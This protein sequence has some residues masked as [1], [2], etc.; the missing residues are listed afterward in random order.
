MLAAA[1]AEF[2]KFRISLGKAVPAGLDLH[3]MIRPALN[4]PA[5]ML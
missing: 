1:A 5:L 2:R 3:P 4:R